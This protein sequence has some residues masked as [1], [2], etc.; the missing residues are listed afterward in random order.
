[1][2]DQPGSG[3]RRDPGCFY[4]RTIQGDT[5]FPFADEDAQGDWQAYNQT[6]VSKKEVT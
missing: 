1:M 3:F 4:T 6:S 2:N 5:I